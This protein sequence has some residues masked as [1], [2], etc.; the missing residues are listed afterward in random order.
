MRGLYPESGVRLKMIDLQGPEPGS[1]PNP[2]RPAI[3]G[4]RARLTS[5]PVQRELPLFAFFQLLPEE[6]RV[7]GMIS[8]GQISMTPD[9]CE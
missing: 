6:S 5:F 7:A 1:L 2:A 9:F 4:E 8:A 3:L